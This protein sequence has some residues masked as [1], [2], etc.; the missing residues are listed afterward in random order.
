MENDGEE[1]LAD[2]EDIQVEKQPKKK[3]EYVMTEAR[4]LAL[5]RMKLGRKKKVDEINKKKEEDKQLL[6]KAKKKPPK[7]PKVKQVIVMEDS[8]SSEEENQV[9]IR[10]KRAKKTV[11]KRPESPEYEEVRPRLRRL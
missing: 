1:P 11:E 10:R 9:I 5:E 8:G 7:K 3:R 2:I 6:E 4:K